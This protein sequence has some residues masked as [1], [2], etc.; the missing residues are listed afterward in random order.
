MAETLQRDLAVKLG[1]TPQMVSRYLRGL[2][3]PSPPMAVQWAK[4]LNKKPW[5]FMFDP[6]GEI[7]SLPRRRLAIGLKPKG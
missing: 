5:H 3:L 4:A 2:S 6:D 1:V 7:L